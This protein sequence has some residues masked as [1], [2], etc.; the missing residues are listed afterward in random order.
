MAAGAP[1]GVAMVTTAKPRD[2]SGGSVGHEID[3][4]HWAE[5]SEKILR[6]VFRCFEGQI[7]H[8]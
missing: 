5:R 8:E 4:T 3:L 6:I 7:S 1:S 2:R